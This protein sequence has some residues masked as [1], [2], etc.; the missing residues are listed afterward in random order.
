MNWLEKI[1]VINLKYAI[2][3]MG[4][5][6]TS[7]LSRTPNPTGEWLLGFG[8][9][10]SRMLLSVQTQPKPHQVSPI[11]AISA[12]LW[13]PKQVS[14]VWEREFP[15][16]AAGLHCPR[17]PALSGFVWAIWSLRLGRDSHFSRAFIPYCLSQ[18]GTF[19]CWLPTYKPCQLQHQSSKATWCSQREKKVK[20]YQENL[21]LL[22][23]WP[24]Y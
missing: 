14:H 15:G 24:Y 22:H 8:S 4:T 3:V 23:S 2:K 1:F 13:I 17:L 6:A 21:S 19:L 5:S 9:L 16:F 12:L 18:G 10:G 7:S 11:S 20:L